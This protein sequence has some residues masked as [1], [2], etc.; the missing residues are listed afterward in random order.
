MGAVLAYA[1]AGAAV[2]KELLAQGLLSLNKAAAT[3][4]GTA[5][6]VSGN[7]T[8]SSSSSSSSSGDDTEVRRSLL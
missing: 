7:A 4:A 5:F 1:A 6:T 3:S 8:S 2:Q